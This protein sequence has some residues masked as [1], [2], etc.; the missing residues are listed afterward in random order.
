MQ[1]TLIAAKPAAGQ[2]LEVFLGLCFALPFFFYYISV[3]DFGS[4]SAHVGEQSI[5]W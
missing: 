4:N 5:D 2:T 1:R 3:Q